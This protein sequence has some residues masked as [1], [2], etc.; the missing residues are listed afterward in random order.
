MDAEREQF[1]TSLTLAEVEVLIRR[2]VKEA[3][4]EEFARVLAC[5]SNSDIEG[6]QAPVEGKL[7][8]HVR[9]VAEAQVED[10]RYR[11]QAENENIPR[12]IAVAVGPGPQSS[13][14]KAFY[15]A[16]LAAGLINEVNRIVRSSLPEYRPIPVTG[17]PVSET[18]IAERR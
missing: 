1:T 7:A 5:L 12:A 14:E 15:D 18:I 6:Q 8:R 10:D 13:E 16:L 2:A 4:H 3:V 11:V 17:A 9:G